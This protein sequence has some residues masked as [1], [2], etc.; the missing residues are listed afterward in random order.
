MPLLQELANVV[1]TYWS[2]QTI[3]IYAD[4]IG[5]AEIVALRAQQEFQQAVENC[6]RDIAQLGRPPPTST[7]KT[8]I[9]RSISSVSIDKV[10][11]SSKRIA[12]EPSKVERLKQAIAEARKTLER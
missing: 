5:E 1:F 12:D 10:E 4:T 3:W 7:L 2:S 11:K 9:K 8:G 6:R